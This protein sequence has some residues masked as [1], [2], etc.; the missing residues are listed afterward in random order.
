[1]KMFKL[2]GMIIYSK[3]SRYFVLPNDIINVNI[4]IYPHCRLVPNP[5]M[6]L[7]EIKSKGGNIETVEGKIVAG[8]AGDISVVK[9]KGNDGILVYLQ[10]INAFIMHNSLI[11]PKV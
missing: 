8:D 6:I 1:M 4:C 11:N 3:S 9:I 7:G 5:V 2:E 10:T